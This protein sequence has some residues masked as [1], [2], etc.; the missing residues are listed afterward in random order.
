MR[1]PL[2]AGERAESAQ[3][4]WPRSKAQCRYDT[5]LQAYIANACACAGRGGQHS[6]VWR[7]RPHTQRASRSGRPTRTHSSQARTAPVPASVFLLTH[8]LTRHHRSSHQPFWLLPVGVSCRHDR[9]LADAHLLTRCHQQSPDVL[10]VRGVAGV[11]RP[12]AD[13]QAGDLLVAAAAGGQALWLEVLERRRRPDTPPAPGPA[14]ARSWRQA[15]G[16]ASTRADPDGGGG[17]AVGGGSSARAAEP[18]LVAACC[19]ERLELRADGPGRFVMHHAGAPYAYA[20]AA[21]PPTNS[22]PA[23]GPTQWRTCPAPAPSKGLGGSAV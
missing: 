9:P 23:R 3:R 22:R 8:L 19:G 12:L 7:R 14:E 11:D 17:G 16:A 21:Q 18:A 2:P 10:A 15:P 1:T 13:A 6:S 4:W 20:G 5:V